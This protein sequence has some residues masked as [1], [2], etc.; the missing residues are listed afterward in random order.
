[1][2]LADKQGLLSREHFS[3]DG[4]LIQAWASHKSFRPKDGSD[5]PPADG[6][7]VDTNW[8]GKRRSNDTHESSTD[9]AK[10]AA[11]RSHPLLSGAHPDR[12][13]LGLGGRRSGQSRGRFR[14]TRECIAPAR[15]RA[16]SSRQDARCRQGLRHAR[17]CAGLPN[18]QSDAARRAQRHASRRQ[19]DRQA[20]VA[21]RRLWH[22]PSDSQAHRRALRLRQDRRQ[23]SADRVSRNQ[24]GRPALQADNAGE[25]PDSN[26]TN[27]DGGTARSDAMSRP[28]A[29]V[30]RQRAGRPARQPVGLAT[31]CVHRPKSSG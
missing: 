11:K 8:T 23:D 18:A 3:V 12:E 14:R 25:Q 26:A 16:G 1:M 24:M 13:P 30:A 29:A 10:G 15:L 19:H 22:Q 31:S 4:P 9:P 17:L 21:A 20:D 27:T 28:S 2:R 7:N 5:D 6:R